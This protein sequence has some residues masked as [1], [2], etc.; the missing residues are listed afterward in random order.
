M[1]LS[2]IEMVVDRL[3]QTLQTALEPVAPPQKKFT[4]GKS[5]Q[6]T[7]IEMEDDSFQCE[8]KEKTAKKEKVCVKVPVYSLQIDLEKKRK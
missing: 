6:T 8:F 1:E 5:C 4:I 3:D 7:T 2:S